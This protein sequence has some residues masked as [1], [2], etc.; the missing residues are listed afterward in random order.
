MDP[1]SE[2]C[3]GDRGLSDHPRQIAAGGGWMRIESGPEEETILLLREPDLN[4]V[5]SGAAHSEAPSDQG[6]ISSSPLNQ[7]P[8]S[9]IVTV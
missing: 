4:A 2:V 1:I 9:R 8:A 6:V 3:D 5:R 7:Y